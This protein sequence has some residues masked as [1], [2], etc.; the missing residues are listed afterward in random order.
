MSPRWTSAVLLVLLCC[1]HPRKIY[2]HPVGDRDLSGVSFLSFALSEVQGFFDPDGRP[3][4]P[5]PGRVRE[6]FAG[7]WASGDDPACIH[8]TFDSGIQPA[9]LELRWRGTIPADGS[10]NVLSAG[11]AVGTWGTVVTRGS[12]YGDFWAQAQVVVEVESAHCRGKWSLELAK[13][14]ITGLDKRIA[15]FSGWAEI[16][17]IRVAD[18]RGGDTLDVRV[19]LVGQSNRGQVAV[20]GFGFW[21]TTDEE[22][23]RM[24]GIRSAPQAPVRAERAGIN[25]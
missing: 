3:C 20:D 4:K 25:R 15:N 6:S 11:Y 22:L 14:K 17:D 19:Q 9:A 1:A 16:P 24:F 2:V 12:Y 5:F 21:V 10:Y 23:N 13:A 7:W 18:C 8:D